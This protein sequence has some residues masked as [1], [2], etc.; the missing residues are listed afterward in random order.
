MRVAQVN[1]QR[2]WGGA[3]RHVALLSQGLREAG[4]EVLLCCHPRGGLRLAAEAAGLPCCFVTTASQMD[5]TAALRLSARIARFQPDVLHL[6]TPKDYVC[7]TLAARILRRPCIVLTR[8]MLLKV[9]PVMRRIYSGS[10][11]V[12]CLSDSIRESLS[13]QGVPTTILNRVRSGVE[14]NKFDTPRTRQQRDAHRHRWGAA[15]DDVVFGCVSRLVGGK[16]HEC[17]LAAFARASRSVRGVPPNRSVLPGIRLVLL[18]E[19]PLRAS[20]ENTV[21]QLGLNDLVH[22]AGICDDIPSAHSGLDALILPSFGELIPLSVLEGMASGLPVLATRVGGIPE[23]VEAGETGLLVEAGDIDGLT[24]SISTLALNPDLR[25][26]LGQCGQARVRR[27]FT[28]LSMTT[29]T[30]QV[31]RRIMERRN[32]PARIR[33]N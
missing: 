32:D 5:L 24:E 6:H 9:K 25:M 10:D 13:R 20:L 18:G 17:L 12:V 29:G 11:A 21:T 2:D 30:L 27:D 19:G 14:T 28:L 3:E 15:V 16:G 23:V 33:A 1:L 4:A 22:F 7:G 31:Y 26:R 8:H